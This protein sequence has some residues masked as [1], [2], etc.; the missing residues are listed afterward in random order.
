[1]FYTSEDSLSV[2][3]SRELLLTVCVWPTPCGCV[4][5]KRGGRGSF[6]SLGPSTPSSLTPPSSSSSYSRLGSC[7]PKSYKLR[8]DGLTQTRAHTH[9]F[10]LYCNCIFFFTICYCWHSCTVAER[11]LAVL[12]HLH[13]AEVQRVCNTWKDPRFISYISISLKQFKGAPGHSEIFLY[14]PFPGS[15][16]V[17]RPW[18]SSESQ[19]RQSI[20]NHLKPQTAAAEYYVTEKKTKISSDREQYSAPRPDFI[21]NPYQSLPISQLAN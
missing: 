12:S 20:G 5:K 18:H 8:P 14:C 3:L 1:M 19:S 13:F 16:S 21:M 6:S 10:W 2:N 9:T 7:Y 17:T 4:S 11:L 15:D